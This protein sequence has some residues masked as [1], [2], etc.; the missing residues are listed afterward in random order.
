MALD[1]SP[2]NPQP[3]RV[4]ALAVQQWVGQLGAVWVEAQIVE[5]NN[6]GGRAYLT[7]R[8]PTADVSVSVSTTSAVL[9]AAGPLPAGSRVTAWIKPNVWTKTGRL[10]YDC[11]EIRP[12]GE[13]RLL[14]QLEQRKRMLQAEGLFDPSR[15]A[16][17]PLL[18]AGIG[19]VTGQ[20]TA[21]ERDV[22]DTIAARWP[23]AYVRTV[24]ARVQGDTTVTEVI[25]ALQRLDN[26]PTIEVII[27]ARG[28][29]SLDDLLPFSDESLARAV[30]AARTPVISAIGH[31]T[32]TPILDLVADVRAFTP[33]DAAKQ[34]VP[35]IAEERTRLMQARARLDQAIVGRIERETQQLAAL[36]SRPVLQD[37]TASFRGHE[38][39]LARLRD[40]LDHAVD[41]HLERASAELGRSLAQVRAMSPKATLERGYAILADAD[42]ASVTSVDDVEVGAPLSAYLADGVLDLEVLGHHSPDTGPPHA[43]PTDADPTDADPTDTHA[44]DEETA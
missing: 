30:A 35:D 1:S 19:L 13:G 36:R 3:L 32:D 23:Q 7:L 16:K 22:I 40:R 25:G 31:Q 14:A 5:I 34:V 4:I 41:R 18:P 24:H 43:D 17:L 26:D 11:R 10:S 2:D 27:I 28:G 21:A 12:T 8:D 15:K 42:R 6:R 20:G 9:D 44:E 37:P 38:D 39:V 29:G 33:T